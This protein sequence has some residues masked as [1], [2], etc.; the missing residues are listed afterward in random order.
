MKNSIKVKEAA[1][2]VFDKLSKMDSKNFKALLETRTEG[3]VY[4]SMEDLYSFSEGVRFGR[5]RQWLTK[6][7]GTITK[8]QAFVK[9]L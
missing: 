6:I 4:K 7:F 8:K 1:K 5:N 2:R 3:D 9:S